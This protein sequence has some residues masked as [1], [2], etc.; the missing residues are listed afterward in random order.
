MFLCI[1]KD[2][3]IV[4]LLSQINIINKSIYLEIGT[5]RNSNNWVRLRLQN[6]NTSKNDVLEITV[7]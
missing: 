3:I 7:T 1:Y 5:T 4:D 6:L 2:T